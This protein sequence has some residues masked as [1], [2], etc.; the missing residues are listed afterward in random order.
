MAGLD[1]C[2]K[3]NNDFL[4]LKQPGK[5][6][7]IQK[8]FDSEKIRELIENPDLYIEK[9]EILKDSRTTKAGI[10][11][12]SDGQR[13]FIKRYNNK[14]IL[15]TLRYLAR[16]NHAFRAWQ[17]AWFL[18]RWSVPTPD[19]Y[20]VINNKVGGLFLKTAYLVTAA[21]EN[22]VPTLV[23]FQLMSRDDDLLQEF[24]N[25]AMSFLAPLHCWGIRH[26]DFKL[27][28][29]YAS[30]GD[31]EKYHYGLWDLDGVVLTKKP[32]SIEIRSTDVARLYASFYEVSQQLG[33]SISSEDVREYICNAYKTYAG[34]DL[35][36]QVLEE[37]KA[38]FIRKREKRYSK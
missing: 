22:V 28:N 16:M 26:L 14:G 21:V 25:K 23:F 9:A 31:K 8:E 3:S 13:F 27:S 36:G 6:I 5:D 32:L 12:F 30:E 2:F 10:S 18:Q 33:I 29:I 24:I 17:A 15:Y 1:Y 11:S 34:F 35:D 37:K 19:N 20:V 7:V 38:Y 4:R